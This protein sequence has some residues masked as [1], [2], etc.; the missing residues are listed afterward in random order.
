MSSFGI[1]RVLV[2]SVKYFIFYSKSLLVLYL[3]K[4]SEKYDG[5]DS[6]HSFLHDSEPIARVAASKE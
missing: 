2:F 6:D 4:S 3:I 5:N 1:Y